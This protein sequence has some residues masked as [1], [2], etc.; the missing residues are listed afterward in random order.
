MRS[1]FTVLL[2]ALTL[3]L[4][5]C[6]LR[7]GEEKRVER[8]GSG[9]W[10]RK[11]AQDVFVGVSRYGRNEAEA[12]ADAT[13]DAR[14]QI[15]ESLGLVIEISS[16][17]QSADT[18]RDGVLDTR[19]RSDT[20]SLV[21]AGS[22]IEVQPDRVYWEKWVRL[23]EQGPVY[24][25]KAWVRVPFSRERHEQLWLDF[26]RRATHTYAAGLAACTSA[27]ALL[28]GF[29]ALLRTEEDFAGQLWLLRR[30]EYDAFTD[31]K[32]DYL[33]R[34]QG[35]H[36]V[37][38]L[39]SP[40]PPDVFASSFRAQATAEGQPVPGMPLY[41]TSPELGLAITSYTDAQGLAVVPFRFTGAADATV[42]V[43]AGT[44]RI[45]RNYADHVPAIGFCLFSPLNPANLTVGLRLVIE[46]PEPWLRDGL[47]E[48]LRGLG[49]RVN[50][51]FSQT[52]VYRVEG[53]F[54]A[55][56]LPPGADLPDLRCAR[57]RLSLRLVRQDDGQAVFEYSL[58]N[59]RFPDT[60]GYGRTAASAAKS[61]VRLANM[62]LRDECLNTLARRLDQAISEDVRAR[63][64]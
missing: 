35:L 26:V 33:K 53:T 7:P 13:L 47:A 34:L 6:A 31:V 62:G 45:A 25:Y 17:E 12:L 63:L 1:I 30:P 38:E 11:P 60:R 49:Y 18:L 3:L 58:P 41:I 50:T 21:Y 46:P 43:H 24:S 4:F 44:E 20:R 8:H 42:S 39:S 37:L 19:V 55:E 32:A 5:A 15:V 40:P 48:A 36:T 14:R 16:L 52:C 61:S 9:S 23:T 2:P 10:R 27:S 28:T 29:D 57:S 54:L 64:P 56:S 22:L 59:D 51:D